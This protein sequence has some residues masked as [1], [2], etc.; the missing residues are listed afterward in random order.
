MKTS[1]INRMSFYKRNYTLIQL[2][3]KN[4]QILSF[5]IDPKKTHEFFPM[6]ACSFVLISNFLIK[7]D[8]NYDVNPIISIYNVN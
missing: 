6:S 4:L 2:T 5:Y 3:S 7:K 8:I 1:V